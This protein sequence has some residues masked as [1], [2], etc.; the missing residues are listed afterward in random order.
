MC[1]FLGEYYALWNKNVWLQMDRT[2]TAS[3]RT[4]ST[5]YAPIAIA[6]INRR[7]PYYLLIETDINGLDILS[8]GVAPSMLSWFYAG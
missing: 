7:S 1:G 5:L 8:E 4:I 3:S 2:C 6:M